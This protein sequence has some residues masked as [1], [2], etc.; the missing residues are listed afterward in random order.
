[1]THLNRIGGKALAGGELEELFLAY[2]NNRM[3]VLLMMIEH[4]E[5]SR[6]VLSIQRQ[7]FFLDDLYHHFLP[8]KCPTKYRRA[9]EWLFGFLKVFPNIPPRRIYAAIR[10]VSLVYEAFG[11]ELSKRVEA[12]RLEREG[13]ADRRK[14]NGKKRTSH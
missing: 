4:P 5:I 9:F 12:V 10:M 14:R 11:L 13:M 7:R 8:S 6:D 2:F 3:T 1:M